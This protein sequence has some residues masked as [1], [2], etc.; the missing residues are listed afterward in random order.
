MKIN[1]VIAE[2]NPFH[3]GHKNHIIK[4]KELTGAD[5][6]IVVMSGNF[7]QR[8]AP[9]IIDKYT[10][11]K[12]ALENGA[13]LV[14]ELP[15]VYCT[16]SAEYFALGAVSMLDKLGVVNNLCFGSESGD[17]E[18]LR[19]YAD[20]LSEEPEEYKEYLR[21]YLRDGNSYP[22]ARYNAL[23][24]YDPSLFDSSKILDNPNNILAI[25]YL[26][27]L[28]LRHSKMSPYTVKRVSS[29]YHDKYEVNKGIT[30]SAQAIR[31]AI[32]SGNANIISSVL[33]EDAYS[34]MLNCI[35]NNHIMD[36]NDFSSMLYY[37]L[38]QEKHIGF[39]AYLDVTPE[40]SDR[41]INKLN[42]FV[43]FKQFAE[44]IKSKDRTYTRITRALLH[45]LLDITQTDM[46]SYTSIDYVGYARVLGF[47]KSSEALLAEIKLNSS[48][49]MITNLADAKE[50]LYAELGKMF[51][52]E[53]RANEIYLA[54]SSIKT[55]VP[56]RNE[57]STPIVIV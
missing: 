49:P 21:R 44:L 18:E 32:Y 48:I 39:S 8:G 51:R 52:N 14:L 26:K 13:D 5:Y 24:H 19:K 45:I 42:E 57:F 1:G 33:P 15:T 12:I 11:T 17:I 4:S 20:I 7:V 50:N 16:A 34:I 36:L 10:R 31:E 53:I 29:N 55:G 6:T 23:V 22:L 30:A 54:A 28:K 46:Y 35:E 47:K 9:A 43:S 41:I 25:E 27:A 56:E 3:N 37:K 38:L 2:Y 40:L